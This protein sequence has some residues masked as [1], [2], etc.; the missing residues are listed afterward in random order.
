MDQQ[1]LDYLLNLLDYRRDEVTD[2]IAKLETTFTDMFYLHQD[3]RY[4]KRIAER[5]MNATI[6]VKLLNAKRE[7]RK[8]ETVLTN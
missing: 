5:D 3:K 2:Q 6:T 4:K 1:Q 8:E 7:L